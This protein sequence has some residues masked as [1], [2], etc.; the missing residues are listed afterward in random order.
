MRTETPRPADPG[1]TFDEL[2]LAYL[3][4][5][6]TTKRAPDRDKWSAKALQPHFTGRAL[7]DIGAAEVRRYIATR[8]AAGAAPGTV[9]KEIGL[10]SAALN[11]ARRELEWDVANPWES[12]RLREPAGRNRWLTQEEAEGLIAAAETK[13][14]RSPWLADF[15]R[16]C[17]YSGLRPGEALALEWSRVDL[18]RR[19]ITF[20]E[21]LDQKNGKAG[22]IP[23]NRQATRALVSRAR[24]R[25]RYC[26]ASPWVFCRRNGTRIVSIKTG[27]AACAAGAGVSNCHPHDL[28]RT[29]GSWLV[30]RG[31]GIERVSELLRHGDVAITAKVYAHLRPTDLAA[32]AA[33]LDVPKK[34]AV[35]RS[36]FT[37]DQTD[38]KRKQKIT[39]T[40]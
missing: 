39:V 23:L 18:W 12:R 27:F 10:M 4:E 14:A 9:N 38:T 8:K 40:T 37:F 24:F 28:R 11:W 35:S 19:R 17:L 13:I 15:I 7:S 31:V 20:K 32:A 3:E 33:V 16:L 26:P 21:G 5:V 6:T 30:Q 29:F 25:A 1:K 34:G 36:G 22:V 2:L